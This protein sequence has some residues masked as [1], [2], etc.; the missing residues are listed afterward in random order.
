MDGIHVEHCIYAA[1]QVLVHKCV[2]GCVTLMNLLG[3]S[4]FKSSFL[5]IRVGVFGC[6]FLLSSLLTCMHESPVHPPALEEVIIDG[7]FL[8]TPPSLFVLSSLDVAYVQAG[9]QRAF[10]QHIEQAFRRNFHTAAI[11]LTCPFK[12]GIL[13]DLMADQARELCD[14]MRDHQHNAFTFDFWHRNSQSMRLERMRDGV[15][16]SHVDSFVL[17]TLACAVRL[18]PIPERPG[19]Y[20]LNVAWFSFEKINNSD[21]WSL[22]P[23]SLEAVRRLF[24]VGRNGR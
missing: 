9:L 14:L 8:R 11:M 5:M 10:I 22:V 15:P 23:G 17:F 3:L 4:M 7:D 16:V 1:E 21:D 18:N 13:E 24:E 6:L 12:R 20:L 19:H 2:N